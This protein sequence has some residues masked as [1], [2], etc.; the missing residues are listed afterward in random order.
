MIIF[1]LAC[2]Q[3]DTKTSTSESTI[4]VWKEYDIQEAGPFSVGHMQI[5]HSYV[6][7]ENEDSREIILD[8]WYPSTEEDGDPAQY[9]YG[10]DSLAF[11]DATIADSVYE[12]GYPVHLHSHGY[13]GWGATSSNLMIHFASHGWVSIAPNH[14]GNLLSDHESPLPI[15][16]Y[17][18]RPLD[19]Q[20][21]LN[22]LE[23]LEEFDAIQQH[24]VLMSGHSFGAGYSAWGVGGATFTQTETLCDTG[25]G[26]EDESLRCTEKEREL[27]LSG[28]LADS[29]ITALVPMAGTIRSTF[30]GDT[31]H[32]S[33]VQP[34]LFLSGTEDNNESAQNHAQE[35]KELDFQWLSL[36]GGCHQTFALGQCATL[37]PTLGFSIVSSYVLAFGRVS[38]LNEENPSIEAWLDGSEQPYP[39]A[40]LTI[41][42]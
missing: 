7:I 38:I 37:E 8:I 29:R 25:A 34:T 2:T 18:H 3:T 23:G 5:T 21:S 30:F 10:T 42:E 14:T 1:I 16:H 4:P 33:I 26:L 27:F 40:T 35:M 15:A 22:V 41:P 20:E 36:E 12:E 13:R 11:E 39:E 6:P 19:L 32:Q 31:G 28:A 24:H 17:I 9:L